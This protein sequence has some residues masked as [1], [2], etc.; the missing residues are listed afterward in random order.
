ME[1]RSLSPCLRVSIS[2]CL[3][4]FRRTPPSSR[5][6]NDEST[7]HEVTKTNCAHQLDHLL[8]REEIAHRLRQVPIRVGI[9]AEP[10]ADVRHHVIEIQ[11]ENIFP[12]RR[13]RRSDFQT[14]RTSTG[15]EHAVHFRERGAHVGHIPQHKAV[16]RAIEGVIEQRQAQHIACRKRD[17]RGILGLPQPHH[18]QRE[19][20]P[21]DAAGRLNFAQRGGKIARA[22][23]KIER[24]T[25]TRRL[26]QSRGGAATSL[27]L[28]ERHHRVHQIVA[29]RDA[30]EH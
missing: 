13:A 11:S 16:D 6:P 18:L 29:R 2:P 17:A 12:D 14:D 26:R 25:R 22:G 5:A 15:F 7:R 9:A 24:E 1:N 8:R 4:L 10:P 21:D 19:I 20:S 30:V 23:R 27:M 28:S 3:I